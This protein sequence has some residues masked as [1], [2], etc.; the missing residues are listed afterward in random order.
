MEEEWVPSVPAFSRS[1]GNYLPGIRRL[2]IT[3]ETP[4]IETPMHS[5]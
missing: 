4:R 3:E 2:E 1:S 5:R